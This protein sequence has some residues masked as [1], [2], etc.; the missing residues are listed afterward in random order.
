M[1]YMRK[2]KR[3][4][5]RELKNLANIKT[6]VIYG[7]LRKQSLKKRNNTNKTKSNTFMR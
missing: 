1:I 2:L 3:K 7:K 5:E 6:D 4:R